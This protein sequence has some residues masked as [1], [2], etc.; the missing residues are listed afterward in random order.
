MK[1]RLAGFLLLVIAVAAT[2]F[3]LTCYLSSRKAEDQW[4]WMRREFRLSDAQYTRILALHAAYQPICANHCNRIMAL[5]ERMADLEKGGAKPSPDYVAAQ[6]EWQAITRECN[7][8]TMEHLE[9][10]AREMDPAEGRRYLDLMV[11]RVSRRDHRGA[12]EVQ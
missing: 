12:S 8:A 10:V 9:K 7:R 2:A 11:P 1:K 5:Q 4:T 6:A 3:G